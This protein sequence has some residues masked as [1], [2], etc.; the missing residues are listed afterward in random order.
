MTRS[1]SCLLNT[2]RACL[3]LVCFGA[4]AQQATETITIPAGPFTMGRTRETDDDKKGMRPLVLR[5]DRPA[6]VVHLD[7]FRIDAREVTQEQYARFIKATGHRAPYH[8]Q[9]GELP[10]G[11]EKWPVHN[12]DWTDANAYC[13]WVRKRLPTEA[14]WE[15]AARGG[16]DGK[17]FP[18]GDAITQK[19]A[20]FNTPNGPG[21]VGQYLPNGFGLFDMAGSLSE[22]CSD[23]FERSY[24]EKSPDKNPTGPEDGKYKVIRGGAWSD[25]PRRLTVFFRN[26][27]RPDQTTPNIGFRCATS[28]PAP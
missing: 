25:G 2:L 21:P 27:V 26:W 6:H 8:W 15:K 5:D 7:E 1:R 24:Y 23:W 20:R 13:T 14:E 4:F 12:V 28:D 11:K 22:W 9:N 17:D 10:K 16:L 3:W 19:D 18:N